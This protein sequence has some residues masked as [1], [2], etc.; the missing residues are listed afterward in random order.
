MFQFMRRFGFLLLLLAAC[1][2]EKTVNTDTMDTREPVAIRYVGAPELAVREQANDTA[3]ILATYQNGEAISVLA[4]K[5][6]WVEVRTGD[7][8]GWAHAA[9]LTNAA[10]K[11]TQ[12]ENPQP[13]F[14]VMP[15]PV[16]A[17]SAHGEIYIEA[18][19]NSDGEVTDVRLITNTTGSPA[20]AQQ[21]ADSLRRAKFYPI[22][23][24]GERTP[25]K[26]YHKV[27]Y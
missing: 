18:N 6:D 12:E 4:E 11:E 27:T 15:L 3:E 17:P 26:Y 9:D 23:Q 2:Q 10:G 13:K 19:V 25:F 24:K 16:S 1:A 21:N 8:S 5:G 22:M 7:R 20:L 14:R